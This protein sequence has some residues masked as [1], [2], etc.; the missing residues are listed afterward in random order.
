MT[1]TLIAVLTGSEIAAG[2]IVSILA[3]LVTF[4]ARQAVTAAKLMLQVVKVIRDFQAQWNEAVDL[5]TELGRN[6]R[7][8]RAVRDDLGAIA[9][10]LGRPDLADSDLALIPYMHDRLHELRNLLT[11]DKIAGE[12]LTNL[13]IR[14]TQ[15][16]DRLE[17]LAPKPQK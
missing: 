11:K 12:I 4:A 13:V 14:L 8:L 1:R 6:T 2:V 16:T 7:D 15:A 3:A 5:A 17:A 9:E 10:L